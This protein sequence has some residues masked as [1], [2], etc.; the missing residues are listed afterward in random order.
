MLPSQVGAIDLTRPGNKGIASRERE[1]PADP[2]S[3][4]AG[5][6]VLASVGLDVR[7]NGGTSSIRSAER[8]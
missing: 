1:A 6:V 8:S 4:P 7:C 3:S 5:P 2:L